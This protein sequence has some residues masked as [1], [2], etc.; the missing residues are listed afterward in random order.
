MRTVLV[1]S[2]IGSAMEMRLSIYTTPSH[3]VYEINGRIG[4]AKERAEYEERYISEDEF[5]E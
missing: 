3:K 4:T 1:V 2:V 5:E